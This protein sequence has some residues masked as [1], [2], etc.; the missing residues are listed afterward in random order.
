VKKLFD[1]TYVSYDGETVEFEFRREAAVLAC[2][3][4]PNILKL[5]G[6]NLDPTLGPLCLI[7]ELVGEG[8]TLM[9]MLQQPTHTTSSRCSTNRTEVLSVLVQLASALLYLHEVAGYVHR[10]VK[11]QNVLI[12]GPL[13]KLCDFGLSQRIDGLGSYR[14]LGDPP[15]FAGTPHY[16][17][18]EMLKRQRYDH[19]ID[20]FSFAVVMWQCLANKVPFDGFECADIVRKW[21][22]GAGVRELFPLREDGCELMYRAL[23][24]CPGDRPRGFGDFSVEL[25]KLL[26]STSY[27]GGGGG[28][29]VVDHSP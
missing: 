20:I 9:T 13:A 3:A 6:V 28:V 10:D 11:P 26:R 24:R 18:P 7:T 14:A 27:N 22:S 29:I 19:T 8:R 17:A 4:H 25:K 21:E 12:Q 1:P 5:L 2:L 16:M 23:S 15:L